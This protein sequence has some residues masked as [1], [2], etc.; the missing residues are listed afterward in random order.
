[1]EAPALQE[2]RESQRSS[3]QVR[4]SLAQLQLVLMTMV[5]CEVLGSPV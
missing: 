1:V 2:R 3:A 5:R 4:H